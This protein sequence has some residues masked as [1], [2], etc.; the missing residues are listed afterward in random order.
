[1]ISMLVM[2]AVRAPQ[3]TLERLYFALNWLNVFNLM[4]GK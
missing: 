3:Y 2:T 1:M 4:D